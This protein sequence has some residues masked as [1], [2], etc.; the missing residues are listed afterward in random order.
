M[1]EKESERTIEK[2][3]TEIIN[4]LPMVLPM[5]DLKIVLEKEDIPEQRRTRSVK[6][7]GDIT[8]L[9]SFL[10]TFLPNIY[11]LLKILVIFTAILQCV[12]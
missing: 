8:H 10:P 12:Y 3:M 11:Q 4:E 2:D 1:Q 9:T 6:Y 5:V 7:L